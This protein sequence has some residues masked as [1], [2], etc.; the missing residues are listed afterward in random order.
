MSSTL[1]DQK[2]STNQN[3]QQLELRLAQAI[4]G[5]SPLNPIDFA[6]IAANAP[7]GKEPKGLRVERRLLKKTEALRENTNLSFNEYV[8]TA[9]QY[10]NACYKQH[11]VSQAN[12]TGDS[13]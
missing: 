11:L 2:T 12:S 4:P 7:K 10:F 13:A 6:D 9:L 1:S 5:D 8:E 3:K